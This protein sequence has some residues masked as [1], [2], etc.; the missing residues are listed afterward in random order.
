M[1][2]VF[3]R[4]SGIIVVLLHRFSLELLEV[5]RFTLELA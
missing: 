5:E 3:V 1:S 4:S 2:E